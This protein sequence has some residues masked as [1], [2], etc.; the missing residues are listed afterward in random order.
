MAVGLALFGVMLFALPGNAAIDTGA[1]A[2]V[3]DAAGD[4]KDTLVDIAVTVLPYAAAIVAI[5]IGWR[6]ARRFVRG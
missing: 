3:T 2:A 5:L 6:L 4:L 1:S